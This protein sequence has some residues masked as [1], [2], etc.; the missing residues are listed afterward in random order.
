MA[1]LTPFSASSDAEAI[2]R[3]AS[4]QIEQGADGGACPSGGLPPFRPG[5]IAGAINNAAG[6]FSPF[7]VRLFRTDAE[8]EFTHFSIKLPPGVVGQAGRES[9]SA[10]RPRSPGPSQGRGSTAAR[11]SS[12]RP[13]VRPHLKSATPWPGRESARPS[14]TPRARSTSRAPTTARRSRWSRSPP[15]RSGPSTSATWSCATPSRSTPKSGEVFIDATGSDP[16]PHIIKGVP[17]HARDIRAYTDRP[18]FVLNPT[19]CSRTS[20]A[21][22]LLGKWS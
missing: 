9:P 21:S 5:L 6:R 12:T 10:P 1:R 18:D 22:T 2:T 8:Q 7:N 14:P 15:P 11:K 13:P 3:E 19:S 17:V 16:I 20:T 4:F